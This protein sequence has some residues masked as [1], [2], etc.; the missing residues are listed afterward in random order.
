M[1]IVAHQFLTNDEVKTLTGLAAQGRFSDGRASSGK[2][3]SEAKRNLQMAPTDEQ[4]AVLNKTMLGALQRCTEFHDFAFPRHIAAIR[5]N[6]Y[7]EGMAYGTHLD[8]PLL[9]DQQDLTVRSD[10][11]FTVFLSGPDSY[12]GGELRMQTPFGAEEVKLFAGDAV[13][14]ATVVP[15]EVVEVT[16][17]SRLAVIGWA[18]SFVRDPAQRQILYDLNKAR[19]ALR[20]SGADPASVDRLVKC[21]SNLMRMWTEG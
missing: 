18:Q 8:S 21:F 2:H 6:R 17:G 9:G 14:Y 16:R 11:S 15:H 13:I 1:L 12:D 7:D 3:L 19:E 10:I 5:I 20:Q 4:A